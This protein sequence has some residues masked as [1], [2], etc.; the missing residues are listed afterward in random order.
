MQITIQSLEVTYNKVPYRFIVKKVFN[1]ASNEITFQCWAPD[2]NNRSKDLINNEV[3]SFDWD[4]QNEELRH[5]SDHPVS[6]ELKEAIQRI[7]PRE[8]LKH[9]S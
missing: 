4:H 7:F 5:Y 8:Q 9:V 3:L 1:T 2:D 6:F